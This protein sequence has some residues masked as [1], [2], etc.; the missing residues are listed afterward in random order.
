[1]MTSILYI[2]SILAIALI[3]KFIY[4]SY[5]T[6]NTD[7]IWKN[8]KLQNPQKAIVLENSSPFNF[9]T[10]AEIRS[11]G[12]YQSQYEV[13]NHS[14]DK[15]ILPCIFILNPFGLIAQYRNE[16]AEDFLDATDAEIT[17]LIVEMNSVENCEVTKE[18]TK[19]VVKNGLISMFFYDSNEYPSENI[20]DVFVYIKWEGTVIHNGLILSAYKKEYDRIA[21]DYV[22]EI[23]FTNLKFDF[24]S[25]EFKK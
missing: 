13:S 3:G 16:D 25:V 23:V 21:K 4:D 10:K 19:Y 22:E 7:K 15:V 14:G 9:N 8:Y 12:F 18:T 2:I 6:D 1:M 17:D 20:D 5:L 24:K 11:D